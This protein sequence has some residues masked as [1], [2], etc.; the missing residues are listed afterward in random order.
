[1]CIRDRGYRSQWTRWR[2][3]VDAIWDRY[4]VEAEL[5]GGSAWVLVQ[6]IQYY[7][8]HVKTKNDPVKQMS[9]VTDPDKKQKLTLRA[10]ELV[11]A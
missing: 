10:E 3:A 4:R 6:A 1:M 11:L 7:E 2:N 5:F 8:Y 9:V